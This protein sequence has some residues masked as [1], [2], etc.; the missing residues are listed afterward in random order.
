[1]EKLTYEF[2]N[3]YYWVF[4]VALTLR[5]LGILTDWYA[6]GWDKMMD[7]VDKGLEKNGTR[8]PVLAWVLF[9]LACKVHFGIL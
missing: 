3:A 2:F 5:V 8:L 9:V 1:M 6:L 7:K 4:I